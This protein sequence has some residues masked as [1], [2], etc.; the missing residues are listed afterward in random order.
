MRKNVKLIVKYTLGDGCSYSCDVVQPA[1]YSS[2]EV[3]Y[4]DIID[5]CEKAYEE[6]ERK[7]EIGGLTFDV[8]SFN[9]WFEQSI[10]DKDIINE[11]NII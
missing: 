10:R 1:I 7:F 4:C 2:S 6:K 5:K 8:D 11:N 9:E 3:L